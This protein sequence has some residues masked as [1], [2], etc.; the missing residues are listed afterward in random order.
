MTVEYNSG[1]YEHMKFIPGE[2]YT[3]LYYRRNQK[4][5]IWSS[6]GSAKIQVDSLSKDDIWLCVELQYGWIKV[7]TPRSLG[8][9][10]VPE[11]TDRGFIRE[12]SAKILR[13]SP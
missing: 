12:F 10:K 5:P 1:P 9:M 4:Y 8:Y 3:S 7:L 6:V 2:C 13:Y 11:E